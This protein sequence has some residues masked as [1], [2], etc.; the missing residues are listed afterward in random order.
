[1]RL[2]PDF[3]EFIE[4]LLDHEVAFLVVGGYAVA[5]H[6]H[7]RYTGDLDL[8]ILVDRT[9]AERLIEALKAF[10]FGSLG[11]SADDFLVR[12]QVVQ[13]GREPIRIDLLTGLDGVHFSECAS[14]SVS[15]EVDGMNVPF[16]S[17]ADLLANKR[18]SGRAQ[19]L[20]DIEALD[21]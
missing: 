8:W 6:G 21:A 14:R 20:A 3:S 17:R 15:V 19:D 12:D 2:D 13:L 1:M 9:N 18:A 11:L 16:I 5:A 4:L 10:G 7:P